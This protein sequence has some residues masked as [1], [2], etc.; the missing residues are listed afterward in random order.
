VALVNKEE[1]AAL[2]ARFTRSTPGVWRAIQIAPIAHF[3]EH[4]GQWW[5]YA[6]QGD[7]SSLFDDDSPL[8]GYRGPPLSEDNARFIAEAH[9]A[10]PQ[11]LD[12]ID[13]EERR[14]DKIG[15]DANVIIEALKGEWEKTKAKL[16][17]VLQRMED[18][19]D[20]AHAELLIKTDKDVREVLAI[21]GVDG[22]A[23]DAADPLTE[24][25][26][27]VAERDQLILYYAGEIQTLRD[28]LETAVEQQNELRE[29]LLDLLNK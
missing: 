18:A 16:A 15:D 8:F 6:L 20:G 19:S 3:C 10:V 28:K 1:R 17:K 29:K 13:D 22:D 9:N 2:R 14:A 25:R 24:V 7:D 11:L 12:A 4:A 21:C 23:A 26:R 27:V 5:V